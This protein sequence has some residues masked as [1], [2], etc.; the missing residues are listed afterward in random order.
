MPKKYSFG[1]F[2][3]YD[4]RYR[5]RRKAYS[6]KQAWALSRQ[7]WWNLQGNIC[8]TVKMT[9]LTTKCARNTSNFN[10]TSNLK[11]LVNFISVFE[12][13][14]VK[15]EWKRKSHFDLHIYRRADKNFQENWWPRRYI[16]RLLL[17]LQPLSGGRR[18]RLTIRYYCE[19]SRLVYSRSPSKSIHLAFEWR[20]HCSPFTD[21]SQL[22]K[23]PSSPH[24]AFPS[25]VCDFICSTGRADEKMFRSVVCPGYSILLP[26]VPRKRLRLSGLPFTFTFSWTRSSPSTTSLT[27]DLLLS[28]DRQTLVHWSG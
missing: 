13:V 4:H 25:L 12:G 27:K 7:I 24:F 18:T 17:F 14:W 2:F 9:N 22:R 23:S 28:R 19:T 26:K 8:K 6:A 10:E 15:F 5:G 20:I 16:L 21:F 1:C 11:L 3:I